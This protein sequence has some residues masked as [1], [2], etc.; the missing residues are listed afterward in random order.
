MTNNHFH[1]A[2]DDD[3][4]RI[5]DRKYDPR[6]TGS[7]GIPAPRKQIAQP[8]NIEV[9]REYDH[10]EIVRKWADPLAYY[11]IF[12]G[13]VMLILIL[14]VGNE[15]LGMLFSA[16]FPLLFLYMGLAGRLNRTH[17]RVSQGE[18]VVRHKPFPWVNNVNLDATRI[19]QLYTKEIENRGKNRRVVSYYYAIHA[20]THDDKSI[21]VVREMRDS[22]EA[23]FIEQQIEQYLSL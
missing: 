1:K 4:F 15:V 10:L 6:N 8:S 17:I 12:G 13:A 16:P 7:P 23:S 18:I 22:A 5:G 21:L 9:I 14:V 19:K 20:L 2:E 3:H 11:F